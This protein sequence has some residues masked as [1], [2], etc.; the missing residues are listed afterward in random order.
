MSFIS[1]RYPL[2]SHEDLYQ[3]ISVLYLTDEERSEVAEMFVDHII[4][5]DKDED[6]RVR[7]Q[8]GLDEKLNSTEHINREKLHNQRKEVESLRKSAS[9][10]SSKKIRD[11]IVE[12][13]RVK[14]IGIRDLETSIYASYG[15]RGVTIGL[16]SGLKRLQ[17]ESTDN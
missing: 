12:Q 9:G 13:I 10:K 8:R 14:E 6:I 17:I 7:L 11:I 3:Q 5:R 1:P 16:E 15:S 2:G 4:A